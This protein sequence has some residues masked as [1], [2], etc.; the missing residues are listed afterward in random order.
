MAQNNIKITAQKLQYKNPL[1]SPQNKFLNV[2]DSQYSSLKNL[3]SQLA[4]EILRNNQEQLSNLKILTDGPQ[5]FLCYEKTA[6]SHTYEHF[7][8][9]PQQ[10]QKNTSDYKIANIARKILEYNH[11]EDDQAVSSATVDGDGDNTQASVDVYCQ[12]KDPPPRQQ[13]S[14]EEEPEL[15]G[16]SRFVYPNVDESAEEHEPVDSDHGLKLENERLQKQLV[17]QQELISQMNELRVEDLDIPQIQQLQDALDRVKGELAEER[18]FVSQT[19]QEKEQRMRDLVQ[20]V[21]RLDAEKDTLYH[22]AEEY[23]QRT[24]QQH[25]GPLRQDNETLNER[26]RQLSDLLDAV[27]TILQ[28]ENPPVPNEVLQALQATEQFMRSDVSDIPWLHPLANQV[29][30]LQRQ[31]R[32]LQN[33]NVQDNVQEK[34][35]MQDLQRTNQRL[36]ASLGH[37]RTQLQERQ[38]S[39][40]IDR[41][42]LEGIIER[43][44]SQNRDLLQ[45]IEDSRT[46]DREVSLA[47]Q[48]AE[49]ETKIKNLQQQRKQRLQQKVLAEWKKTVRAHKF[50]AKNDKNRLGRALTVW[51]QKLQR[52]QIRQ[53][54]I[55]QDQAI[56]Q[57]DAERRQQAEREIIRTA[58]IKAHQLAA[59]RREDGDEIAHAF[60][61]IGV[62]RSIIRTSKDNIQKA[63]DILE[64]KP[65]YDKVQSLVRQDMR[66]FEQHFKTGVLKERLFAFGS[67]ILDRKHTLA[68]NKRSIQKIV[69]SPDMAVNIAAHLK[70][71]EQVYYEVLKRL[72][73]RFSAVDDTVQAITFQK[74]QEQRKGFRTDL[75]TDKYKVLVI[76][77]YLAKVLAYQMQLK[78]QL[79][80]VIDQPAKAAASRKTR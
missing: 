13:L 34:Q 65:P 38:G 55:A 16:T 71:L 54:Q 53:R 74:Q 9:L 8:F 49:K 24:I 21:A 1:D 12:P 11:T 44:Q 19:V 5:I 50:K 76:K 20:Q 45:Q 23:V 35:A 18:V 64:G 62:G 41:T 37:I 67:S 26:V 2:Q 22:E 40:D 28:R 57:A 46:R 25:L 29:Q 51:R 68:I 63:L 6:S 32:V 7:C 77:L 31:I 60:S 42:R 39:Y 14:I 66:L 79:R 78:T 33:I 36:E 58:D 43:L 48:E 69:S 4:A 30:E 72:K 80:L 75:Q 3:L 61:Q 27:Q 47:R 52:K 73:E 15:L 56:A 70:A 10:K 59:P 17:E